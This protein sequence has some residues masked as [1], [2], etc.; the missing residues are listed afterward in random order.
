VRTKQAERCLNFCCR[1]D[2]AAI[3]A[4]VSAVTGSVRTAMAGR[5]NRLKKER[6]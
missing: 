4:D 3:A 1:T 2:A 5:M 6:Q